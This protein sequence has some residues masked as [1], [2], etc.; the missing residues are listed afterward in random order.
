MSHNKK[1][2]RIIFVYLEIINSRR[3]FLINWNNNKDNIKVLDA[4]N[5]NIELSELRLTRER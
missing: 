2:K 4:V 3:I 1:D 5:I